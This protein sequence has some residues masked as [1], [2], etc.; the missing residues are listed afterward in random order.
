MLIKQII[1]T[2]AD[3][4]PDVTNNTLTVCLHTLSTP[5]HN[6]AAAELAKLLTETETVFPGT[7]IRLIFKTTAPINYE[8]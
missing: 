5:G 8:R 3:I 1:Q 2:S 6:I 4:I 7:D